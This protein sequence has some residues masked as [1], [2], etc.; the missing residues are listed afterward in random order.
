MKVKVELTSCPSTGYEWQPDRTSDDVSYESRYPEVDEDGDYLIGGQCFV[1]FD[2][3]DVPPDT[4]ITFNYA[5]RWETKEPHRVVSVT[6]GSESND[7]LRL[8]VGITS[9]VPEG[10]MWESD[11]MQDAV[12]YT[13]KSLAELGDG[14]FVWDQVVSTF[15]FNSVPQDSVTTFNCQHLFY[16]DEDPAEVI[17]ITI[18]YDA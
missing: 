15:V 12:H 4:K 7:G 17:R 13:E 11:R 14:T 8:E 18:G 2:F 1:N 16:K 10:Y 6:I 9:N 3:K 5:R